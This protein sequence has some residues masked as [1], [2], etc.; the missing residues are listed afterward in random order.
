[1]I[2]QRYFQK[3]IQ[4]EPLLQNYN[5]IYSIESD[6]R[7]V[8]YGVDESKFAIFR[9][10]GYVFCPIH[11]M[12]I[13]AE[14]MASEIMKNEILGIYEDVKDLVRMQVQYV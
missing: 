5:G 3:T 14:K 11:E 10:N 7:G 9:A 1:M 12:P 2:E 4:I 8:Y 6:I 13:L